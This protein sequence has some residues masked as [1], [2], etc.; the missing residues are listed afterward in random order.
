MLSL[1]VHHKLW[2]TERTGGSGCMLRKEGGKKTPCQD[3]TNKKGV[4]H[5]RLTESE[6][7]ADSIWRCWWCSVCSRGRLW[8]PLTACTHSRNNTHTHTHGST[9][10][11][12][13][14]CDLLRFP[15]CPST[16]SKQNSWE[17]GSSWCIYV[18]I[19]KLTCSGSNM[20]ACKWFL[21]PPQKQE[22]QKSKQK[23][24]TFDGLCKMWFCETFRHNRS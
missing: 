11:A 23:H 9:S 24:V 20:V 5:E 12:T 19:Y 2:D 18:C 4:K 3:F 15:E 14:V 1:T 6:K 8:Q 17:C 13:L 7:S 21:Q 22:M 16:T 10:S